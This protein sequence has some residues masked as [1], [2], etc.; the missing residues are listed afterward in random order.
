[1]A[2]ETD[3]EYGPDRLV[4]DLWVRWQHAPPPASL[5]RG[6][7]ASEWKGSVSWN[8]ATWDFAPLRWEDRQ[9]AV[10]G[11][12]TEA[13]RL[14]GNLSAK[15]GNRSVELWIELH[16]EKASAGIVLKPELVLLLV[17]SDVSL[18]LNA[19]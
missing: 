19:F 7:T 6:A 1:L 13:V 9:T 4:I 14:I 10:D 8:L 16:P 11:A 3:E 18:M 17:E 2:D 5:P 15:L 12:L